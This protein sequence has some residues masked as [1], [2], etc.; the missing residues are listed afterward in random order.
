MSAKIGIIGGSGFYT[1]GNEDDTSTL[2]FDTPYSDSPVTLYSSPV[3]DQVALFLPRHGL[4]HSLPPHRINYRANLWA[5]KQSGVTSILAIN[6]VGGIAENLPPGKLVIPDQIIDYTWGRE[7]TFFD[8]FSDRN[9]FETH[10]DFSWPFDE[11][12]RKTLGESAALLGH[13]VQRGGVYG[14]TQGPRLE[15]AAE[16]QRMQRDGCSM[17]GMTGMPEAALA[18]ELGLPYASI[19]LVVN[20][21][22]GLTEKPISFSLI[23]AT[24]ETGIESIKEII[25]QTISNLP[26]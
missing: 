5:L 14:C 24:V 22:A 19:A 1:L 15:T 23:A 20:W 21:A 6:V 3:K 16:I 26:E 2:E 4:S 12:L 11:A 18:R 25:F 9:E 8:D 17:V 7:H 13:D 10:V